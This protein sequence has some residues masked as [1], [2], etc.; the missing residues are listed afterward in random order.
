M[1]LAHPPRA[2]LSFD[3][4]TAQA[5]VD[6]LTDWLGLPRGKELGKERL[7]DIWMRKSQCDISSIFTDTEQL[8]L[9]RF[10]RRH[11]AGML[12]VAGFDY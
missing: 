5:S 7:G 12:N 9:E 11:N 4:C 3:F 6:G 1:Y 10:Y 2:F 8:T